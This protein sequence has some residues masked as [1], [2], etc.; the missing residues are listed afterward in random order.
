M[1]QE[2]INNEAGYTV[3]EILVALSLL[4]VISAIVGSVFVF[5]SQ[6]LGNWRES[7][8]QVNEIHI[9]TERM[10]KDI[11]LSDY[12]ETTDTTILIQGISVDEIRYDDLYHS[13][14]RNEVHLSD[15]ADS[16]IIDEFKPLDSHTTASFRYVSGSEKENVFVQVANRKPVLWGTYRRN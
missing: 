13:V 1:E 4:S 16:L 6:Q 15:H 8:N 3:V 7:V 14:Q 2:P 5:T 12:I 9:T 10:Y 11:L